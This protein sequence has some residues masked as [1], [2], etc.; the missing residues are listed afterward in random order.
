MTIK[1]V[2]FALMLAG[3]WMLLFGQFDGYTFALGL[4]VGLA[5][6]AYSRPL[7]ERERRE[8]IRQ[9]PLRATVSTVVRAW[10]ALRLS[11][12]YTYEMIKCNLIMVRDVL[13][14]RPKPTS[15]T[16]SLEVPDLGPAGTTLLANLITLTPGS[17]TIDYDE[18]AETLY[19]HTIYPEDV[20]Q[21]RRDYRR[22]AR[23]IF[24]VIGR[25]PSEAVLESR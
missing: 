1:Q 9:N 17:L 16:F 15:A 20:E 18:R 25:Q 24:R 3:L 2:V 4:V 13:R 11:W 5:A 6:M 12:L 14:P 7:V 10:A 22:F 8:R 23:Q 21:M 19:I